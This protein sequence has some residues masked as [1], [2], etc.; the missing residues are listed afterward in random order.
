MR[1]DSG[2]DGS[3]S[4]LPAP[5]VPVGLPLMPVAE[6]PVVAV[7]VAPVEGVRSS[8]GAPAS[9]VVDV[10]WHAASSTA[11][12]ALKSNRCMG[13]PDGYLFDERSPRRLAHIA[14]RRGQPLLDASIAGDCGQ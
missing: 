1:F 7:P 8:T 14:R 9:L 5:V 13:P 10:V 6:V 2:L 11:H 3:L 12:S 4:G